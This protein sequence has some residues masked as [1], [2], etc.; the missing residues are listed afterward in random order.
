[1]EALLDAAFGPDRRARTVYRVRE[2]LEWLPDL[3]YAARGG[4]GLIATLQSWPV[5]LVA[6][7]GRSIPLVLVGPV[8]V[9]PSAQGQGLGTDLMARLLGDAEA[10][11][12]PALMMVGD[13]EYYARF[14]FSAEATGGW[15]LPGPFEARRL[16]ARGGVPAVKG[17]IVSGW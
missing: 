11:G 6:D 13:P 10:R 4:A 7:E 3:S 12:A 5:R 17:E 2:G 14:G 8:A 1:M 16:L 9:A 15:R